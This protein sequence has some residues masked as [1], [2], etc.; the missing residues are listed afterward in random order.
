MPAGLASEQREPI[1]PAYADLGDADRPDDEG[2][3]VLF[4]FIVIAVIAAAVV[5]I[6]YKRRNN[7]GEMGSDQRGNRDLGA[8]GGPPVTRGNGN[9]FGG[10]GY[11]P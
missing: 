6:Q 5:G 4:W 1:G 9:S 7:P 2:E 3:A 8:N 10:S 11:G